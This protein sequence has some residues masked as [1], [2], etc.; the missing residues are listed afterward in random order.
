MA[1]IR[2]IIAAADS[3]IFCLHSKLLVLKLHQLI[4]LIFLGNSQCI[5]RTVQFYMHLI[6][7]C[8]RGTEIWFWPT[9]FFHFNLWD[10]PC[11]HANDG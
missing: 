11:W 2:E 8:S 10:T 7:M 6:V 5:A 4:G 9:H 1:H 3:S